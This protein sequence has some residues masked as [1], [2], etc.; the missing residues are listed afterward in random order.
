MPRAG[1]I[2]LRAVLALAA[3][4]VLLWLATVALVLLAG[5]TPRIRPADAILVLG[6]AQ[7]NG[8]PSPV[9]RARIDHAIALYRQG[10]APRIVFT[11]GVGR[12]D[13]RSQGEVARR[14]A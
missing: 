5:A 8:R 9:L 6:A 12:G 10:L 14:Y 11:G 7:Y 13:T 2:W 1:T 4:A 3:C